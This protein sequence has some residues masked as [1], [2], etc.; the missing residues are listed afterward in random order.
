M[1]C[2]KHFRNINNPCLQYGFG[3]LW[4]LTFT[5]GERIFKIQEI[6]LL[7]AVWQSFTWQNLRVQNFLPSYAQLQIFEVEIG[8]EE[9]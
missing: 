7:C 5:S 3:N 2:F 1:L 9:V 4:N 6:H 8:G